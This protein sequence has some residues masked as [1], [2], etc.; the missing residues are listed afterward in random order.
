MN[1]GFWTA[2][3][4]VSLRGVLSAQTITFEFVP[5]LPAPIDQLIISNQYAAD[6]GVSFRYEDGS[7]PQLATRG[8]PRTAF[9]GPNDGDDNARL[10]QGC[11]DFFL[12]DDGI[13][14]TAPSPL[15]ITYAT[16]VAAA[17]GVIIDIDSAPAFGGN[18]RWLLEARGTNDI[19]LATNRLGVTTFNSGEG[20]ATPWNF[21]R[22]TADILSIR[23]SYDGPKTNGIGLAFDN[24]SPALPLA[25]AVLSIVKTQATA[26]IVVDGSIGANYVIEYSTNLAAANWTTVTNAVLDETPQW[27]ADPTSTNADRRFYRA[28]GLP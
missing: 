25:P 18:E 12:T 11:G 10:N 6:F 23:I 4:L 26:N 8:S 14:G 5:G 22:P 27:F 20:L 2:V 17:S 28:V 24:F 19:L 1:L 3:A 21:K 16:P 7:Y 13:V 15:I 9:Q